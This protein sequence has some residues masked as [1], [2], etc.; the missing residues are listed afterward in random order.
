M[1]AQHADS[2]EEV[3]GPMRGGGPAGRS[4]SFEARTGSGRKPQP[5]TPSRGA[6]SFSGWVERAL[7]EALTPTLWFDAGE[8]GG[9]PYEVTVQFS[10]RRLDATGKPAP[11]DRFV[12]QQTVAGIVPDSGPVAITTQVRGISP[13]SWEVQA[14]VIGR[15][16]GDV[17]RPPVAA[18][19]AAGGLWGRRAQRIAAREPER[20]STAPWPLAP[21]PGV[22]RFV[23]LR[24]VLLGIAVGVAAQ[25]LL[26]SRADYDAGAALV[27]SPAA[28]LLGWVGAKAWYIAVHRGGSFDGWCVQG[29]ILG[30]LAGAAIGPLAGLSVSLGAYL[31]AAA[32]ALMF[33]IAVGKPGCF[34]AGCCAGRPTDSRWGIWSSDRWVGI[35]RIPSPFLEALLAL[36]I[37]LAALAI[38]LAAGLGSNGTL[39][40]GALAAYTLGRQ[41]LL[42]LRAQPRQTRIGR[43]LTIV[44]ASAVVL[45]TAL[46]NI[47]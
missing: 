8:A 26:L 3:A 39:L 44:A 13:G 5:R 45:A 37:G 24:L 4:A 42:P 15:Q 11:G 34:W 33:G 25:A 19:V 12:Q 21:I 35:R 41:L 17:Y 9:E 29:A 28:V 2:A 1:V 20:W 22:V 6:Q 10:G 43:P 36:A 27:V 16:Y 38:I 18:S 23:W 30:G 40:I 7:E 47:L 31:N 46:V 14:D 32:P